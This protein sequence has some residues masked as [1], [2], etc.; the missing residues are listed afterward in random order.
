VNQPNHLPRT[1][2]LFLAGNTV[3]MVGTGLVLPYILIYLHQV[4]GIALPLVG[5]LLAGA[6]VAGLVVVP[7]SGALID[8]L[9]ARRV[10]VAM[11]L[12]QAVADLGLAW[13][14]NV[15][16][17]LP[18]VLLYGAFWAPMFPT[19]QTMIAVL[20]PDPVTQQRAFAINFTCQNAA[21]GVGA[22]V[23]AA[24]AGAQSPASFAALFIANAA[25]CVLFAAVLLFVPNLQRQRQRSEPKAGYRDVL[26]HRGLR[27]V[28]IAALL[29]A[30]TGYAAFDSG[31]PAFATVVAHVPIRAIALSFT[32]NTTF[33]V[34]TQ[35]LVLR[36]IRRLRRSLV[37]TL[38][39]VIWAVSWGVFGL[40]ALP[41]LSGG[42]SWSSPS[43]PCSAS[44]RP[45]SHRR[46]GPCS[47]PWPTIAPAAEQTRSQDSPRPSASSR[48]RPSSPASSPQAQPRS[49]SC[50][51]AS[52]VLA[53]W[54]SALCSAAS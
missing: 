36:L 44:A 52:V 46:W 5:A 11:M 12:A 40:S 20:T 19:I 18:A 50:S 23:G 49:G 38:T 2:R 4:R 31:V 27:L 16:T 54:A 34:A 53:R 14:H 8:H 30:F 7:I 22:A 37:V 29:L 17:A 10:L 1:T 43:L 32:V 13:A 39:G 24:V 21:L 9:G 6:A 42:S 3:S 45:S 48:H 35:L 28:T 25:S 47:T 26:A 33:I 51:C 15:P 41:F